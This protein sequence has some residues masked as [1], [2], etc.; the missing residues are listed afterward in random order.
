M[1]VGVLSREVLVCNV[2][3]RHLVRLWEHGRN[4]GGRAFAST[5]PLLPQEV[6]AEYRGVKQQNDVATVVGGGVRVGLVVRPK[7]VEVA[8][9][10]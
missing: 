6:Q 2:R 7:R 8:R 5:L 1:A 4:G 3:Q 10:V 9:N